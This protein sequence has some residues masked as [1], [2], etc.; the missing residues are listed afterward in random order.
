[1]GGSVMPDKKFSRTLGTALM[2][3]TVFMVTL[4]WVPSAAAASKYR[5]LYKFTGGADGAGPQASLIFD[6]A[7][8]LSGTTGWGGAHGYGSVFALTPNGDGSWTESVLHSFNNDGTDGTH[9]AE[10][11]LIIDSSG[12]LY[13]TTEVG[14]AYGY[15]TV[16]ALTP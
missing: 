6:S 12:T 10:V 9:P 2:V 16:F 3:V 13:G 4:L 7:G 5:T 11:S 15:G 1:M 8:N 14:G